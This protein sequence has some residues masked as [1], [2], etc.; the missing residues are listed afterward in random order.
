MIT[1]NDFPSPFYRLYQEL[2]DKII[3]ALICTPRVQFAV[4]GTEKPIK[5]LAGL[6]VVSTALT[7]APVFVYQIVGRHRGG[8]WKKLS[9]E[10]QNF[11]AD[12]QRTPVG[13]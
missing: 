9:R 1:T 7:N 5:L 12:N 13:R 6:Q 4:A 3:D 11:L 8:V 10:K 2:I